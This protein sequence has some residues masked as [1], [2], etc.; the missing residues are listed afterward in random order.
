MTWRKKISA[1]AKILAFYLPRLSCRRIESHT[2]NCYNIMLVICIK[3]GDNF[4]KTSFSML[5][6]LTSQYRF[7]I[8]MISQYF[9]STNQQIYGTKS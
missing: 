4:A 1:L 3:V 8:S 9:V 5:G 2:T 7:I 6:F